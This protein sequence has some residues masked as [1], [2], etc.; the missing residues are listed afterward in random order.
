LQRHAERAADHIHIKVRD[1]VVTLT[2]KVASYA[3]RSL[4]RGAA[5]SAPGVHAVVDDL[6]VA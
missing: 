2:G 6:E 4:A 5:W 3:E 1:G